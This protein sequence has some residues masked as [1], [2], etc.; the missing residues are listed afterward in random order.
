MQV[1]AGERPM[2]RPRDGRA[3]RAILSAT[4]ELIADVGVHEFRTRT[5]PLAQGSGR[6]P[7]GPT[8]TLWSGSGLAAQHDGAHG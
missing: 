5:S 6:A 3:D 1:E 2:G 8:R 4:L 7:S